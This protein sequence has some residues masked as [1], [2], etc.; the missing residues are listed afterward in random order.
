MSQASKTSLFQEAL[1]AIEAL[2]VNDQVALLDIVNNR[3]KLRQRQQVE[4]EI[5]EIQ[6]EYGEGKFKFGSVDDFLAEL[7]S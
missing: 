6:Q 2:P 7:D 3:L 4:Q 5:K 1:N